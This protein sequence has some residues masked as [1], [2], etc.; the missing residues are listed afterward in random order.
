MASSVRPNSASSAP[1]SPNSRRPKSAEREGF[2]SILSK[3]A[4]SARASVKEKHALDFKKL[5]GKPIKFITVDRENHQFHLDPAARKLLEQI[6][7]PVAIVAIVGHMRTGK[8][9]LLNRITGK[10]LGFDTASSVDGCTRGIWMWG[11]PQQ[12][13]DGSVLILLDTE[14]LYDPDRADKTFDSKLFSLSVLLASYLLYNVMQSI[15]EQSIRELSFVADLSKL[16]RVR[17]TGGEFASEYSLYFP[18]ICW[19]IRDFYL[20]LKEHRNPRRYLD[21]CLAYKPGDSPDV[22]A[23]NEVKRSLNSM[24]PD[25]KRD[26]AVLLRPTADEIQLRRMDKIPYESLR[27]EFRQGCDRLVNKIVTEA[28]VKVMPDP[29]N[30]KKSATVLTGPEYVAYID[31]ILE[32]INGKGVPCIEYSWKAVSRAACNKALERSLDVYDTCMKPLAQQLPVSS[33][34]LSRWHQEATEA[35]VKEFMEHATGELLDKTQQQ[36]KEELAKYDENKALC[37]GRFD[38]WQWE[39]VRKSKEQTQA[40]LVAIKDRVESV[41]K[42]KAY[43]S[44]EEYEAEVSASIAAYNKEGKGPAVQTELETWMQEVKPVLDAQIQLQFRLSEEERI[45]AQKEQELA[46]QQIRVA[47]MERQQHELQLRIDEARRLHDTELLEIQSKAKMEKEQYEA[48][49]KAL[50]E[51]ARAVFMKEQEEEKKRREIEARAQLEESSATKIQT[52][53]R[54]KKT[55][56]AAKKELMAKKKKD[57]KDCLIM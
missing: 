28:P 53:Y 13:P 11:L 57:K 44:Y 33:D 47:E 34:D 18:T 50:T 20:S 43:S 25:G 32:A 21:D 29:T 41:V 4:E 8:S 35:A 5:R 54:S 6:T 51:D 52:F 15:N 55:R 49:L 31:S 17:S 37:G 1:R 30:G 10:Q 26:C 27:L 24:F 22:R 45:R 12:R 7:A 48:R 42:R 3:S 36:L 9:F 16:L 14:G 39:N 38:R 19:V 56:E 40:L 46:L 2:Q 23:N